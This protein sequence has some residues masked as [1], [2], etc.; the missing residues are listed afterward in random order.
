M[1]VPPGP[2][3]ARDEAPRPR[4]WSRSRFLL[5]LVAVVA[6]LGLVALTVLVGYVYFR[7]AGPPPV[8]PDAPSIPEGWLSGPALLAISAFLA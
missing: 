7:P 6:V 2:E 4:G 5:V 1:T 3:A 8:G